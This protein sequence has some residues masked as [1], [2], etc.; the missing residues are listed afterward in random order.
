MAMLSATD[1]NC[2]RMRRRMVRV[3]KRFADIDRRRNAL[4]ERIAQKCA[5][6][7]M[8]AAG[9]GCPCPAEMG[10][11]ALTPPPWANIQ[12]RTMTMPIPRATYSDVIGLGREEYLFAP[13]SNGY[14]RINCL[15]ELGKRRKGGFFKRFTKVFTMP[16]KILRSIVKPRA[17]SSASVGPEEISYPAPE[18]IAPP[19]PPPAPPPD[20]AINPTPYQPQPYQFPSQVPAPA[21]PYPQYPQAPQYR[22]YASMMPS[23]QTPMPPAYR[24]A[25]ETPYASADPDAPPGFEDNVGPPPMTE[26]TPPQN[27]EP[28]EDAELGTM[29][30]AA[31]GVDP[32]TAFMTVKSLFKRKKKKK[33]GSAQAPPSI[34]GAQTGPPGS[35]EMVYYPPKP[36]GM[37]TATKVG[38]GVAAVVAAFVGYRALKGK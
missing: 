14:D 27:E 25:E 34:P 35:R 5:A 12:A 19:T 11:P 32:V 16:F 38:I 33:R 23:A 1:A 13:I 29:E 10:Q 18:T 15:A 4:R 17:R 7:A 30:Q 24:S 20:M 37:S 2:P 6:Q 9:I 26:N 21:Y 36:A 31:L 28:D 3:E 8:T 22:D